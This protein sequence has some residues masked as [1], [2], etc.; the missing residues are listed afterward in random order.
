[1]VTHTKVRSDDIGERTIRHI[2]D[3]EVSITN[4]FIDQ[5]RDY[6]QL[7]SLPFNYHHAIGDRL[8]SATDQ[9]FEMQ[10]LVTKDG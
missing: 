5:A 7:L 10:S 1:M 4:Y 8:D 9:A 3:F 6:I 2:L